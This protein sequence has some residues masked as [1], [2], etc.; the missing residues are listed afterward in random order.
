MRYPATFASLEHRN[1][2]LFWYGQLVSLIGTWIQ[3]VAQ[4]WY[5]LTLTNSAFMLGAVSA[6]SSLPILVLSLP[7]G[8][9]ADRVPKRGLLIVTQS[10]AMVMA[11]ALAALVHFRVVRLWHIIAIAA[12]SG[13]AFAFDAPA[14]QSY[15][16][17]LVPREDLL[18]AIALNS[19]NFNGTRIIGPALAGIL[20]AAV[21][22]ATCFFLNGVSFLAV[23]YG[24]W[25]IDARAAPPPRDLSAW[26]DMRTG[27]RFV[28][29][30]PKLRGFAT[31]VAAFSIFGMA[32]AV[33]MPIFARDILHVGASGFGFLMTATGVGALAGALYLATVSRMKRRGDFVFATSLLFAAAA[34]VLAVSRSFVLTLAV[35]PVIGFAMVSQLATV[36][37]LV[38]HLAPDEIR[39]RAMSVHTLMVMGMAPFGSFIAGSI[40]GRF[41]APAAV[42]VGALACALVT[43]VL[44]WGQ[45]EMRQ[46]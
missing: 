4:S 24:L 2:R 27:L 41:G 18:N 26:Q 23:I 11:F 38:Q 44:Y 6:I 3:N 5:V 19:A 16:A 15:Q 43:A 21:G 30:D 8:V 42:M 46:V 14:R 25:L 17:E 35:M 13:S 20:Y 10:V 39:G 45:P 37:T 12:V 28:W 29:R 32:Y 36:N 1:Y 22:A 7:G 9:V 31:I 34:A 40:A 33:L